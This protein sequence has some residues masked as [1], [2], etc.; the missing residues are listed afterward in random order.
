MGVD[1]QMAGYGRHR[2]AYERGGPEE[3]RNELRMDQDCF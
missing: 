2:K 3:L 1:E